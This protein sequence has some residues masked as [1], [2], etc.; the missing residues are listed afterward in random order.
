MDR[1]GWCTTDFR[2]AEIFLE[3][4][5]TEKP[6]TALFDCGGVHAVIPYGLPALGVRFYGLFMLAPLPI[7]LACV[8]LLILFVVD[9]PVN[10]QITTVG[11][12]LL[13]IILFI[14]LIRVMKL[15]FK[16][17][18]LFPRNY[19]VT[20]GKHGIAMHF[21]RLH[22]PFHNPGA[23]ITW[24]D[25]KSVEAGEVF[26]FPA[27]WMGRPFVP[28][29]KVTGMDGVEVVIPFRLPRTV[30]PREMDAVRS[31]IEQKLQWRAAIQS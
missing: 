28:C 5:E 20:I 15:V 11:I 10:M 4:H 21:T 31:L 12:F 19:F 29:L 23:W 18:A 7:L 27:L 24:H 8:G 13:C 26:F 14:G 25:V 6:R 1:P 16:N 22:F 3:E 30:Q 9:N 2:K 17:R